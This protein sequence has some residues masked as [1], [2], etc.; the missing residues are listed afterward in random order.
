MHLEEPTQRSISEGMTWRKRGSG[1][2]GNRGPA[3]GPMRIRQ[4]VDSASLCLDLGASE[5]PHRTFTKIMRHMDDGK[6]RK[7]RKPCGHTTSKEEG[8]SHNIFLKLGGCL[9]MT[10]THR[11]DDIRL[12]SCKTTSTTTS[13]AATTTI[14][15]EREPDS[16]HV[17]RRSFSLIF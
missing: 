3:C 10:A 17:H 15:E 4:C 1:F 7:T 11:L 2:E 8:G 13:T 9:L 14:T 5:R 6:S 12:S 16:P